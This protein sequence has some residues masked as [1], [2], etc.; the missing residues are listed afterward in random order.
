MPTLHSALTHTAAQKENLGNHSNTLHAQ[1]SFWSTFAGR[2]L[3]KFEQM[4][5]ARPFRFNPYTQTW[6]RIIKPTSTGL[7]AGYFEI[8]LQVDS[9]AGLSDDGT[10]TLLPL[11]V[12]HAMCLYSS[13]KFHSALPD[14]LHR[15]VRASL[16]DDALALLYDN[17]FQA[18]DWDMWHKHFDR[19]PDSR[20]GQP[21]ALLLQKHSGYESTREFDQR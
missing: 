4:V 3:T 7:P 5:I 11:K 17:L 6:S 15:A 8:R 9:T 2:R 18:I 16:R 14:H 10:F 13:D 12:H 20:L 19:D 1:C 21:L